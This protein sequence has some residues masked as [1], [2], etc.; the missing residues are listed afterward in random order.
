MEDLAK[1][2]AVLNIIDD[3]ETYI[4]IIAIDYKIDIHEARELLNY[5]QK[6]KD[7]L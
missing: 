3:M 5:I 4:K 1:L 7:I 6:A 2:L